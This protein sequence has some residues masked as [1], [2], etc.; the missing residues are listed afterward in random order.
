MNVITLTM[1]PAFDVHC[2]AETLTLHQENFAHILSTEAGG[3]GVNLS[4]ALRVG[5]VPTTSVVVLGEENEA[6][7]RHCLQKEGLPFLGLTVSGRIRENMTF[8]EEGKP[9]TRISFSGFCAT[10]DLIDRI[11]AQILPLCEQ[12]TVL[13]LTGRIPEGISME[14]IH[15]F[16]SWIRE[17][18]VRTVVDSRSFDKENLLRAKPYLIKPN[19]EEIVSYTGKTIT[20]LSEA[21]DASHELF[22]HGIE[23]VMITLGPLG[24]VLCCPTGTYVATAPK[25]HVRST[26]GAGDSAIAGFLSALSMGSDPTQ[27]LKTAVAFGSAAC[28]REGTTPPLPQDVERLLGEISVYTAS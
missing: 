18:G 4:R 17:K 7:F 28:L 12:D 2:K 25:L 13:T 9:E 21:A 14:R 26:V 27:C 23:N 3:K 11:E 10:D 1:S 8:H 19:E 16:L 5:K 20:T 24:A 6:L 15:R 22:A